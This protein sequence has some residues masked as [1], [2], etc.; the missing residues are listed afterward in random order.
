MEFLGQ[1]ALF[2]R[3]P[4]SH[5]PILARELRGVCWEAGQLMVD[6]GAHLKE[7]ALVAAGS[8]EVQAITSDGSIAS[9][10][11]LRAG[12]YFGE[13]VLQKGGGVVVRSPA[14][15]VAGPGLVTLAMSP[16]EFEDFGLRQHL[17]FPK[18][19]A[20]SRCVL[21]RSVESSSK[22]ERQRKFISDSLR[23][24]Q[25]LRSLVDLQESIVQQMCDAANRKE[26]RAGT[27]IVQR[28]EYGG[29]FYI[30]ESG[31][32]ELRLDED[33]ALAKA[34]D[35]LTRTRS[36][37]LGRMLSTVKE[38]DEAQV[39][40][41]SET[42]LRKH[43]KELFLQKLA[44][45]S[46]FGVD[47]TPGS[48]QRSPRWSE[49]SDSD[50]L[51]AATPGGTLLRATS[52]STAAELQGV[53]QPALVKSSS[54][55]PALVKSSSSLTSTAAPSPRSTKH[56]R[57]QSNR[58]LNFWKQQSGNSSS[59]R[60][61]FGTPSVSFLELPSLLRADS[62][63]ASKNFD[64]VTPTKPDHTSSV[65]GVRGRG[66]CFGELALLYHAPRTSTA[67]AVEDSAVWAV[68][69]AQFRRIMRSSQQD[70][71]KHIVQCL[72]Q[73]DLLKGLLS[74]EKVEVAQNIVTAKFKKGDWLIHEG[75]RQDVW[76]IITNGECT[77]S[78]STAA[79]QT[80]EELTTLRWPQHF[81]ERALL[82]SCPS[83]FSVR[84]SSDEDVECLVLDGPTFLELAG[85]LSAEDF[86]RAAVDDLRQFAQYKAK[87]AP[88]LK[89]FLSR[90]DREGRTPCSR[91]PCR[92]ARRSGSSLGAGPEDA[93]AMEL[94]LDPITGARALDRIGILGKGA[95]GL[96]TLER[97][98]AT[99]QTFALKTVSKKHIIRNELQ[100]AINL[101]RQVLTMVDSPFII[102]LHATY[103]DANYLYFLFEPLLGGELHARMC[104]EPARFRDPKTYRFVLGCVASALE[105]LHERNIVYRDLKPENLL[106][107]ANGYVKMC[108]LGFAKFVLGK[109]M[110]LCG[111]PEYMAPEVIMHGGYDRMVDWWALGVLAFECVCGC[112]PFID[113]ED[114]DSSPEVIFANILMTREQEIELPP[115]TLP[116]TAHFVACLL[117]FSPGNRMGIGGPAQVKSHHMFA[118]LDFQTLT[119]QEMKAPFVPR[120]KSEAEMAKTLTKKALVAPCDEEGSPASSGI[121]GG[122][123][124]SGKTS[125]EDED[126][127]C[128]F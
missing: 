66:E 27:Q 67:V 32:F 98:P 106:L 28:G 60:R 72:D 80:R 109:T 119:Q 14:R 57:Q 39:S 19:R 86:H 5:Y 101:E 68:S 105:H 74:E 46:D 35:A 110:T 30:V 122:S 81:G 88:K 13:R 18:R 91:T 52:C 93:T 38:T 8:A 42:Y 56:Q 107:D 128:D 40:S 126:W 61:G 90:L 85:H 114:D 55:L 21:K 120:V 108:D 73:V 4:L 22:D 65:L 26:V 41:A 113:E 125:E 71:V 103:R 20:L 10:Q 17:A 115:R 6:Q 94:K 47:Q 92:G 127:D 11:V 48:L 49:D 31:C 62:Q 44:H 82:R 34:G 23:A 59:S 123:G 1:V 53:E 87:S 97:D 7:F 36:E 117:Q 2:K 45:S 63:S 54:S 12:D 112:T 25:N 95:F 116:D 64:P 79:N 9:T 99:A 77:M 104:R 37:A 3:L 89:G 121:K 69:Q 43:R 75:E 58:S 15:I 50:E 84:A 100:K 51:D 16:A 24:N 96:V 76:Y 83:E 70:R 29:M 111:T 124:S 118:P 33:A 78:R 102:K